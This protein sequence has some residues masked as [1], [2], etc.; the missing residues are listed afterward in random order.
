MSYIDL[1]CI[2]FYRETETTLKKNCLKP[3]STLVQL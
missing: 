1:M 2:N 3:P